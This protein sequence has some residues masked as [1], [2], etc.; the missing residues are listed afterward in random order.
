M[1]RWGTAV[2]AAAGRHFSNFI[3]HDGHDLKLLK[4]LAR[5]TGSLSREL[6][7]VVSN[8]DVPQ[9]S[10]P[11]QKLPPPQLNT[12]AQELSCTDPT[13]AATV[14]NFLVDTVSPP[15]NMPAGVGGMHQPC[16]VDHVVERDAE[17]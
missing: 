4:Q 16:A 9:H 2:D 1:Y 5:Q 10:M 3:V 15:Q 8:F 7:V 11:P 14:M 13:V 17:Q 12:L 6:T